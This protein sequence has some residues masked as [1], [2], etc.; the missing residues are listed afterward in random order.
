ETGRT[1]QIRV[2]MAALS[3]PV[4]GDSV[5]GRKNSLYPEIGITRQCLHAH[6]LSFRHPRTGE[7]L[8]F[9]APLW[10]DM[11]YTLELLRQAG[12]L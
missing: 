3:H 1:H 4:A 9:T 2:H 7:D 6:T 8:Q 12:G 11:L 5:Y 10:P